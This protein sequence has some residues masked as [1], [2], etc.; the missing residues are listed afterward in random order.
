MLLRA[1]PR[2]RKRARKCMAG[3]RCDHAI[4]YAL[5]SNALCEH[6][7]GLLAPPAR[8]GQAG[9]ASITAYAHVG[10]ARYAR[11]DQLNYCGMRAAVDSR[12]PWCE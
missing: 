2:K 12:T 4:L 9:E 6:S 1:P 10:R 7:L 3:A 11:R 8:V 5:G